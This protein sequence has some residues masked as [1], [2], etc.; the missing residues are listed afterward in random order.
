MRA[1]IAGGRDFVALLK[2]VY[3]LT[4][5]ISKN[6]ITEIVSGCATGADAFGERTA[7]R[8]QIELKQFPAEWDKLG[9]KAGPLRNEKM[10]CY[11]DMCILFPGGRGT[12]DMRRRAIAH[13]LKVIE[14]KD[15]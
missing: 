14:Y 15:V 5:I 12:D 2:H 6:G 13:G 8:M 9:K 10:A 3:W 11:A 7:K 1:I 4:E